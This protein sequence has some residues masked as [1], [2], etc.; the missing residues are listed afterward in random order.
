[1]E[2]LTSKA[3]ATILVGASLSVVAGIAVALRLITKRLVHSALAAD[4]YWIIPSV[5][6]M[7][8][9]GSLIAWGRSDRPYAS[10]LC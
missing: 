3:H 2:N 8:V 7:W 10:T 4:D 6:S 9:L 1:M 5:V